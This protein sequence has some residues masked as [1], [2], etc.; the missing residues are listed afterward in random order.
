MKFYFDV[1]GDKIVAREKY[2]FVEGNKG[3]YEAVFTFDEAWYP[4]IIKECICEV[5]GKRYVIPILGDSCLLPEMVK[6]DS[7]IGAIGVLTDYGLVSRISTR[8]IPFGVSKG[9]YNGEMGEEFKSAAEVWELYLADMEKSRQAAEKAKEAAEEAKN[10]AFTA[11]GLA[12]DAHLYAEEAKVAAETAAKTA[13]EKAGAAETSAKEAETAASAAE[14]SEKNAS[15]YGSEA[16]SAANMAGIY[17]Q[18]ILDLKVEAAEGENA[19]VEKT[20][21]DGVTKLRFTLPKGEK[22]ADGYTPVKGI[23]YF[24]AEDISELNIPSEEYVDNIAEDA[25]SAK[26]EAMLNTA[27]R[28]EAEPKIE[29]LRE[30]VDNHQQW[31]ESN[32]LKHFE[33]EKDLTQ[34]K[35]EISEIK[36]TIVAEEADVDVASIIMEDNHIYNTQMVLNILNVA[37]PEKIEIGYTSMLY[38][39][40]PPKELTDYSTFPENT[41][42]KGDSVEDERFIPE[43]NMR[44]TIVFDYDG[45]NVIGYVSGVSLG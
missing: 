32:D 22:G 26:K 9:A 44:Y 30:A 11:S 43:A 3:T 10:N 23:D 17:A 5:N 27:F 31:L 33:L 36:P 39:S 35:T 34:V 7:Y 12:N 38:F 28:L 4:D 37:F 19:F 21:T 8:M 13:A 41:K 24:T 6:G 45:V 2:S 18:S 29:T 42:F 1:R 40:T 14:T 25:S 15:L 16:T 20:I